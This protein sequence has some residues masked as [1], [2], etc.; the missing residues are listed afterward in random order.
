MDLSNIVYFIVVPIVLTV[1][2]YLMKTH[3]DRIQELEKRVDLTIN[4]AEIRGI[5][6][7]KID[8]IKEDIS[9]IKAT[10][11]HILTAILDK[12]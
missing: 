11:N 4:E 7:D 6:N 10:L 3:L 8:P 9:E 1:L 2:G 5:I 12:R